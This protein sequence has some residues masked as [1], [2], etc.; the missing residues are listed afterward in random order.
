MEEP[1]GV[2]QGVAPP[3]QPPHTVLDSPSSWLPHLPSVTAASPG[4]ED[5]QMFLSG[6]IETGKAFRSSFLR[7]QG[8]GC[9]PTL[10]PGA[11][12]W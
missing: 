5:L 6:S 9:V 2:T 10:L 1:E 4:L 7:A 8:Q 3:A 11:G 12:F